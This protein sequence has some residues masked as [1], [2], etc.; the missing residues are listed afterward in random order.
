MKKILCAVLVILILTSVL[1][2]CGHEHIW[3]GGDCTTPAVC[4]ECGKEGDFL[5]SPIVWRFQDSSSEGRI[6]YGVCDYC[7]NRLK[8]PVDYEKMAS[9]QI[10]GSWLCFGPKYNGAVFSFMENGVVIGLLEEK[11]CIGTWK[12]E[13]ADYDV[14]QVYSFTNYLLL[15]SAERHGYFRYSLLIEGETIYLE[16]TFDIGTVID[17][18]ESRE[19]RLTMCRVS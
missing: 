9:S 5:H 15:G 19:D 7:K 14:D 10:I 12:Y 8:Q 18:M 17:G 1:A 4:S 13:K 3:E 6:M 16:G 2:G 11:E